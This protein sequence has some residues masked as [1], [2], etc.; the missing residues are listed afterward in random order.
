MMGE[1]THCFPL[2]SLPHLLLHPHTLT[3]LTPHPLTSLIPHPL[4][5]LIPHPLTS[6]SPLA[7]DV[8]RPAGQVKAHKKMP[9]YS[10]ARK[11]GNIVPPVPFCM[12]PTALVLYLRHKL[13]S[14]SLL[15]ASRHPTAPI[16][17][18]ATPRPSRKL[19]RT[20]TRTHTHLC[21][22]VNC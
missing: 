2:P 19:L 1:V 14:R 17:L 16:P 5:S 3:T 10:A 6:P 11:S 21:P 4:T 7:P 8:D 20:H 9:R 18:R 12:K 15:R 13:G 22:Y